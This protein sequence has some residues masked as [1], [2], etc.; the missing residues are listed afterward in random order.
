MIYGAN[1]YTG[2]L[3]AREAVTRGLAPVLAGRREG[4]VASIAG[5]LG[6]EHRTFDLADTAAVDKGLTD[7]GLVLHCAG[8]FSATSA[9]M[10]EGCLRAGAHY[11]DIT[12]EISVFEHAHGLD[13][14]AREAGVVVCPGVGFDVIPTDCTAAA[15][16]RALPDATHLRLG[17]DGGDFTLSPGTAKT[18]VELFGEGGRV[19]IDGE[20]APVPQ[21]W[22][23]R[24]IDFGNGEK[25]AMTLPWGDVSTAFH[26]T[27]IPNIEVYLPMPGPAIRVLRAGNG[28]RGLMNRPG[29]QRV[30]KR[31]V[32]RFVTGPDVSARERSPSW[33]WGEVENAAGERLVAR[34]RTENGYSLTVTGALAVVGFVQAGTSTSGYHTPSSLI[35]PEL[36]TALPGSSA[37]GIT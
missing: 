32:E 21:A 33:V 16:A 14:R 8:P 18:L 6:L 11:L 19:R 5:E 12:G 15:L 30:L 25:W 34:V 4:P 10:I 13:A 35:G 2:E 7:I 9:P 22:K 29:A 36:V 1:G 27:G 28:L 3:I 37:M 17:F 31:L 26:S 24:R 23:R 20:I